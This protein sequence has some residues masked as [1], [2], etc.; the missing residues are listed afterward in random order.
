MSI[1]NIIQQENDLQEMSTQS[2][3]NY[4]NNPT[5]QYNPYLV[6]GELQ[7]KEAFAQRQMV[8]APQGTV[9]DELVQKAMPMGGM[10]MG[11]PMGGMPMPRPEEVEVSDTITETG[12]ANLPAP[13]IGQNYADGGIVGY[14]EG[15]EIEETIKEEKVIEVDDNGDYIT[16]VGTLTESLYVP[17]EDYMETGFVKEENKMF[18]GALIPIGAAALA[19]GSKLIK[20]GPQIVNR[21]RKIG[22]NGKPKKLTKEETKKFLN[23]PGGKPKTKPRL[24]KKERDEF[25]NKTR[26]ERNSKLPPPTTLNPRV[27]TLGKGG[28]AYEALKGY[29]GPGAGDIAGLATLGRGIDYLGRGVGGIARGIANRPLTYGS[30]GYGAYELGKDM[31]SGDNQLD[32]TVE[33][34]KMEDKNKAYLDR[35]AFEQERAENRQISDRERAAYLALA[36][37]GATTM[38]GQSPFALANIGAGMST[39]I[40]QYGEEAAA[41]ADREAT[42]ALY[43]EKT[44]QENLLQFAKDYEELASDIMN[45][46]P[47]SPIT[48]QPM[49][50]QEYIIMRLKEIKNIEQGGDD[51]LMVPIDIQ[52]LVNKFG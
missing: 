30:L 49:K 40:S 11:A 48:N 8:E 25:L 52:N 42:A 2:L 41:I 45:D 9:V 39:G 46:L 27:G 47:I 26:Q 29:K 36:Q 23:N 6:A 33:A 16:E 32:P 15:G 5:G 7:R 50:R 17:E 20:Y 18:G 34:Q 37:A 31:F 19:W 10:P 3:A 43:S 44:I 21:L 12:I 13:N 38:A 14:E 24:S 4:L 51:N 1:K 28:R 35:L 22:K